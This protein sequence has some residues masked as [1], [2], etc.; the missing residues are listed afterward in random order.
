MVEERTLG[1]DL[2][3]TT[4]L[5]NSNRAGNEEDDA[6]ETKVAPNE[7]E[8]VADE[9]FTLV[10][11]LMRL[12]PRHAVEFCKRHRAA[13]HV[14]D[15]LARQATSDDGQVTFSSIR[16]CVADEVLYSGRVPEG[17]FV[18]RFRNGILLVDEAQD[19]P[20]E[21]I[22]VLRSFGIATLAVGDN[23]Q[24][25]NH[26]KHEG[27]CRRCRI[28]EPYDKD[29][30][31]W[32]QPSAVLSR[33]FRCRPAVCAFV[34]AALGLPIWSSR[35]DDSRCVVKALRPDATFDSD[36]D[37]HLCFAY[38]RVLELI[39]QRPDE[40]RCA[41]HVGERLSRRLLRYIDERRKT[42]PDRVPPGV[43]VG[44]TTELSRAEWL[45]AMSL[46]ELGVL[47]EQVFFSR[48]V[49]PM[50]QTNTNHR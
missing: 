1:V 17:P 3:A 16:R 34:E 24:S 15:Y 10:D 29:L 27:T 18:D 7:Y 30:F 42:E 11:K 45:A 13:H 36:V 43:S 32:L 19:L 48:F 44:G 21:A 33:T 12:V 41:P 35:L 40:F 47:V 23:F 4:S 6:T 14:W 8:P 37:I 26:I 20:R 22:R 38:E 25:I 9:C 5:S 49:H 28:V 46:H 31:N 50:F 39:R 2:F